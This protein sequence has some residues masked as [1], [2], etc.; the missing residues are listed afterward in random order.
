MML[1]NRASTVVPSIEAAVAD[2]VLTWIED[3]G[4]ADVAAEETRLTIGLKKMH[5]NLRPP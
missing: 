1:T 2:N 5:E 4:R 3:M